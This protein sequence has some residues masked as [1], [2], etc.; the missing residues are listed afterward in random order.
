[1]TYN[2]NMSPEK[3]TYSTEQSD[4]AKIVDK[5]E[6]CAEMSLTTFLESV[7][8]CGFTSYYHINCREPGENANLGLAIGKIRAVFSDGWL[9]SLGEHFNF[10]GTGVRFF[11]PKFEKASYVAQVRTPPEESGYPCPFDEAQVVIIS[12]FRARDI[13]RMFSKAGIDSSLLHCDRSRLT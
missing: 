13:R 8:V 9:S 1:M 10:N 3:I 4:L 2:I 11:H 12:K 7:S 5:V 6:I